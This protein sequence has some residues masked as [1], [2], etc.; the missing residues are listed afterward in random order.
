[1]QT[2]EAPGQ[3]SPAPKLLCESCRSLQEELAGCKR[4]LAEREAGIMVCFSTGG[5]F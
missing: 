2:E 3:K 5:D 4:L 1:M